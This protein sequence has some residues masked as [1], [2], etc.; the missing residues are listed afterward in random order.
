MIIERGA[1]K[2]V[3]EVNSCLFA[4]NF[5]TLELSVIISCEARDV[6]QKERT[7][8]SSYQLSTVLIT[9]IH[10]LYLQ[11][12]AGLDLKDGPWPYPPVYPGYDALAGYHFNG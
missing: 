11:A 2:E 6:W 10:I 9:F 8:M 1:K 5:Y 3:R 12:A 4:L 7:S